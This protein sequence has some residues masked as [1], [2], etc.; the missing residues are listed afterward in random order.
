MH[1]MDAMDQ[2]MN[3]GAQTAGKCAMEQKAVAEIFDQGPNKIT[4]RHGAQDWPGIVS[5]QT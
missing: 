2:E 5:F 1:M 4:K 3:F